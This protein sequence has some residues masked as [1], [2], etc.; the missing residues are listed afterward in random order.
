MNH[1]ISDDQWVSYLDGEPDYRD[2][3]EAH[4]IGCQRCW[5][6]NERLART[7]TRL[8]SAGEA[9][10]HHFPLSD[11]MLHRSLGKLL[12]RIRRHPDY[13]ETEQPLEVRAR[14]DSLKEVLAP[15]CGSTTATRALA[16]AAMGSPARSLDRVSEENWDPFLTSLKSIAIVMCGETG[17]HLVWVSGQF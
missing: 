16:A 17:A 5:E 4:L 8:G 7:A 6:F 10:R 11:G 15:M 13:S 3:I 9:M 12:A 14:L 1:G 2:Q